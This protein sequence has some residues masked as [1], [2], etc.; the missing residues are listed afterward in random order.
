M[1]YYTKTKEV[2]DTKNINVNVT[3]PPTNIQL[4]RQGENLA[5]CVIFDCSGFA[6][7]YGD[8]TAELLHELKDGTIYP[9]AVTQDGAS[10]SWTVSASDTATVGA[11]RAELRW[12]VGDTLA[13][14]AKFRTSVSSALADTTTETPP[15]PQKS[16]VDKV[17]QA[18]Q[19]IKD[20]A[21]SDD[22]LAEAIA[23]YLDEHPIDAG[24]DEDAL[25]EYLTENGYLTDATLADAVAQA[26]AEAKAS[27]QFDGAPGKDGADGSPGA[28]GADGVGI[29]SVVQT[30]TSAEDGGTNVI[31]VTKTD[32]ST[33]TFEVRNGSKGNDGAPGADGKD[34][35]DGHNGA[36]GKSAYQYA[37]DGGYTGTE[38]EF[39]AKM[40]EEIPEALPNP[41]ALTFTGAVNGTYDG[42]APVSV[43]IPG[44]GS[45]GG[46][47]SAFEKIGTIDLSTM[48]ASNLGVE[49]TVTDVTEIVLIWTGMTN[50]TTSNSSLL[51]VFNGINDKCFNTL[52]PRTG[53]AGSP[54]NGYTYLKV[55]ENVGVLPIV[56]AGAISNTNY[57]QGGSPCSYNLIPVKEKI[58]TFEIK[59]PP[60]QYYADAGMVEVYSR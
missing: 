54:Q 46:G 18:A 40:A 13:K 41:N 43:E 4:G 49:F 48:A 47:M 28:D 17:L 10:V 45:G 29:Q 21:I 39:T 19:E 23:A 53:K 32:G 31:T 22:K 8:G 57:T 58:Q 1:C 5:T 2:F 44:G 38:A 50:K 15:A 55:L 25:A 37:V 20:G 3:R 59:Q 14:S 30:T 34:G 33:S 52:G 7:L 27:G 26:L 9:V 36:N 6:Q 16:W 35:V 60:T 42:S 56:S 51:L 24:L 12:Y 11:G